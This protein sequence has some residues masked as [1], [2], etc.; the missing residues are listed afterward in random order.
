[1]TQM[2]KTCVQKSRRAP[3]ASILWLQ[4]KLFSSI[5]L[6][7]LLLMNLLAYKMSENCQNMLIATWQKIQKYQPPYHLWTMKQLHP[8]CCETP[9]LICNSTP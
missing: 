7:L 3:I 6:Q 8:L 9:E 2:H 5:I 4:P 1:M